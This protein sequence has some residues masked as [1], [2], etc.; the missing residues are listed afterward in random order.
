MDFHSMKSISMDLLSIE[1]IFVDYNGRNLNA[2]SSQLFTSGCFVNF[3]NVVPKL[4]YRKIFALKLI[5]IW[6]SL[7]DFCMN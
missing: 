3:S 6:Y 1:S 2:Q 5:A 7:S 4:K